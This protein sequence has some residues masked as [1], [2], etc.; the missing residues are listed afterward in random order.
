MV[1]R[2]QNLNGDC[3][4]T[5]SLLP[6]DGGSTG[7]WQDDDNTTHRG[8]LSWDGLIENSLADPD[9]MN[10]SDERMNGSYACLTVV[11][12]LGLYDGES[13]ASKVENLLKDASVVVFR[14]S[15]CP[16]SADAIELLTDNLCVYTHVV[17][18]D[19]ISYG[20]EI[21]EYIKAKTGQ[22]STPMI[23]VRNQF[24]GGT[25]ELMLLYK[26]GELERET[27]KVLVKRTHTIDTEQLETAA[28]ASPYKPKVVML[29]L[30][31]PHTVNYHV[32]RITALM[33]CVFAIV[34]AAFF[35]TWWSNLVAAYLLVDLLCRVVAGPSLSSISMFATLLTARR[36]PLFRPGAPKQFSALCASLVVAFALVFFWSDFNGSGVVACLIMSAF[37]VAC[38]VEGFFEISVAGL[39]FDYLIRLGV[40]TIHIY[41]LYHWQWPETVAKH[42]W[43]FNTPPANK[44]VKIYT[45]RHNPI[46][47]T[48]KRKS[49]EWTKDDFDPIRHLEIS[50]FIMPLSLAGL[51]LAFKVSTQYADYA[52]FEDSREVTISDGW[53]QA[54]ACLSAFIFVFMLF[55]YLTRIILLPRKIMKEITD[56]LRAPSFAAIFIC[57]EIFGF[58]CYD[59]FVNP[60][61]T[62]TPAQYLGRV[63]FWI[64]SVPLGLYTIS[65]FGRWVGRRMEFEH[66]KPRWLIFPTGLA[67]SAFCAPVIKPF[68]DESYTPDVANPMVGR[69]YFSWAVT[70]WTILF[71]V[72]F[73]K[74]VA[75]HNSDTPERH[76]VWFWV[77]AP[78]ALGIA[79]F[80]ICLVD[81]RNLVETD[82]NCLSVFH[83]YYFTAI[84]LVL[85][86]LWA[87]LPSL[88]FFWRDEFNMGYWI[89]CFALDMIATCAS[90]FYLLTNWKMSA[91]LE[92]VFLT[93]A[94]LANAVAFLHT[95]V[96]LV[97]KH[98]VCT[99]EDKWGPLS[100]VGLTHNA[101][102]AHLPTLEYYL[103]TIDL[104]SNAED[105][106]SNLEL[107][108]AHFNRFRIVHD[109]HL[110]QETHIVHRVYADFF[111]L[112]GKKFMEDHSEDKVLVRQWCVLVDRMLDSDVSLERR[113]ECLA[114]LRR[115]LPPFLAHLARHFAGEDDN[116][117]PIG[118][119]Y[120]SLEVKKQMSRE[121]WRITPAEKWEVIIPYVLVN[122]PRQEQRERYI[123]SLCWSMP[124]RAQQFGAIVYRNVDSVMWT[125]LQAELRE[126]IPRGAPGWRRYY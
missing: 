37:A 4:S 98:G 105:A 85:A 82:N 42:E 6:I 5:S 91:V 121:V 79:G 45:D 64:G 35:Y 68:A 101:I 17:V 106:V 75:H 109:E 34:S 87:S 86:L 118:R 65:T 50:Y 38:G 7:W 62:S 73:F 10:D 120:L 29:P 96:C 63:F 19:E 26:S 36:T 122:L 32:S 12:S 3:L 112:H 123:K 56:P 90:L 27:L 117:E 1:C 48:Y 70:L 67:I 114:Q 116:L 21:Y 31:F 102:R 53:F 99:P 51:A 60:N 59:Q 66:V 8:S 20:K 18:L 107:F 22:R 74:L 33:N 83:D 71:V 2:W 46:A 55:M 61:G 125:L 49:E 40:V 100:F 124:E 69:F 88:G 111:P 77:A 78:A 89:E 23:Y 92:F 54:T 13:I 113:K 39:L 119:K 16:A 28:L 81:D 30:W 84:F 76:G 108:A 52:S 80:S 110:T 58:L 103:E 115:E 57:F 47:L 25:E 97:Q 14:R 24:I 94:A 104:S 15:W 43:K 93:A 11:T 44:P 72:T 95:L 9:L 41:T 126:M